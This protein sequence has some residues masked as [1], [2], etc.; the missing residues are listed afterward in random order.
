MGGAVPPLSQYAFMAWCSV[1]GSTG[2]NLPL[3]SIPTETCTNNG[4]LENKRWYKNYNL[5]KTAE[6][7]SLRQNTKA[8]YSR[9]IKSSKENHLTAQRE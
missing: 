1:R 4:K 9:R 2:T 8:K 7:M 3:C 5:R 6:Y